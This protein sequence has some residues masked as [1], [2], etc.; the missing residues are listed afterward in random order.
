MVTLGAVE[1]DDLKIKLRMARGSWRIDEVALVEVVGQASPVVL[2]P[3]SVTEVGPTPRDR[4]GLDPRVFDR[5]ADPSRHLVTVPGDAYRIWFTVPEGGEYDLFLDTSGYYYEW[6][7]EEWLEEE[8]SER[9]AELLLSPE[10]ALKSMAPGF[11]EIE[12]RMER[13]FWSSRF[14]R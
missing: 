7:R 8:S 4:D 12:P 13:L 1:S 3:D 9:T 6:I 11:K 10:E 14:R 5:L 2:E